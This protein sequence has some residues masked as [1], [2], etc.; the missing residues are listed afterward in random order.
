MKKIFLLYVLI[1]SPIA[2]FGCGTGG[3]GGGSGNDDIQYAAL[4]ASDA[5]GVGA[6][7]ITKGYVYLI[8]DGIENSGQSTNLM[9][10]GVP[11]IEIG[12]IRDAELKL[13]DANHQPDVVTLFTGGND[14]IA[15]AGADHFEVDLTAILDHVQQ[16]SNV[17]IFI[18]DLPDLSLLPRFQKTP[19]TD[20]TT[21][22]VQQFNAIIE[23]QAAAQ[24]AHVVH[25]SA[26]A[27]DDNLISGDGLH[28]NNAGYQRIADLF[29]QEILP[30][31]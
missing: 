13:L 24:Q 30:L 22:R 6:S 10:Y 11:D 2:M 23:R 29:L 3:I 1:L 9:N 15:G 16:I 19:D 14:I 17:K 26:E 12:G 28:P 20:V 5:T 7:P 8:K 18:A 4:G 31:I 25:L 21:A 27:P